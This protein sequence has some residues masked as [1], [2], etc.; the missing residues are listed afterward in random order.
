[1]YVASAGA[2]AFQEA[3]VTVTA[4]ATKAVDV[5]PLRPAAVYVQDTCSV[6][7]FFLVFFSLELMEPFRLFQKTGQPLREQ[8]EA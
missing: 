4:I 2:E 6:L 3:I 7:S 5:E 8:Q 1:M